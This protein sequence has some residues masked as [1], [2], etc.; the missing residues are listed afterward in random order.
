MGAMTK[1]NTSTAKPIVP[2]SSLVGLLVRLRQDF[3][4]INFVADKTFC[5]S[6]SNRQVHYRDGATG[7]TACY[8]LLHELGHA[9]LEHR[10]YRQDLELLE[11]EMA[12][13][14]RASRIARD[15]AVTIDEDYIQNC[16]DTYRDWLYRR[17]ICPSCATK[18]LQQDAPPFGKAAYHCFNCHA[19]WEVANS[20]FCRPYRQTKGQK[21]PVF[22]DSL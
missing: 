9:L 19:T 22:A 18:A 13:W 4:D 16:L 7:E 21:A 20:R 17:S 8:S 12:A 6:P 1:P 15:Y 2:I 10:R 5:W 11:L 3:P 14:E